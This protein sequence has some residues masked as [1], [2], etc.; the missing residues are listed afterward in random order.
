MWGNALCYKSEGRK[1]AYSSPRF[2]QCCTDW[3]LDFVPFA[4]AKTSRV[5]LSLFTNVARNPVC[6]QSRRSFL[7]RTSYCLNCAFLTDQKS[8]PKSTLHSDAKVGKLP[9][10]FCIGWCERRLCVC[11]G[12][13][14]FVKFDKTN[15]CSV[16][17]C[18]ETPDTVSSG[19]W[20]WCCQ[21]EAGVRTLSNACWW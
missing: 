5:A 18:T 15:R 2:L 8:F 20:D 12:R 10:P 14:L 13:S 17:F 9:H 3:H 19:N 11:I 4:V 21:W 1:F 16:R 7:A 6:W